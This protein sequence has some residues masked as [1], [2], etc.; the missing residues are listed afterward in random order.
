M[1]G[2][3]PVTPSRVSSGVLTMP[4]RSPATAAQRRFR[5]R[6][7]RPEE[8][9]KGA[10]FVVPESVMSA[11]APLRRVPVVVTINEYSWRTTI[12]PYGGKSFVPV[13]AEVCQAAGVDAGETVAVAIEHDTAVRRVDVPADVA[14][15][16]KEAGLR[17]A[18]DKLSFSHQKEFVRAVEDAK[19]PETRR[20]RIDE[21]VDKLQGR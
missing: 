14:R 8:Y 10:F 21:M 4:T 19:R 16:L 7:D 2:P 20:R 6:L 5:V 15:A 9:A 12:A 13:R 1:L 3:A 17:K 18:F 11:F